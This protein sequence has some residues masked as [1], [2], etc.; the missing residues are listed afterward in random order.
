[1]SDTVV[2]VEDMD[3]ETFYKHYNKRHLADIGL[4]HVRYGKERRDFETLRAF[5]NHC[6]TNRQQDHDHE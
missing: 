5:H 4:D 6:H 3:N 1:M 2:P